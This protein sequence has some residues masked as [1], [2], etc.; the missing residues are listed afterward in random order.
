MRVAKASKTWKMSQNVVVVKNRVRGEGKA[1][2]RSFAADWS[3][4]VMDS[5]NTR[6]ES[7]VLFVLL[8]G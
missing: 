4:G 8:C 5:L 3:D 2:S 7:L 6:L 1:T